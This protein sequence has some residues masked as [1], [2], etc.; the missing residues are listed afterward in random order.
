M[1]LSNIISFLVVNYFICKMG[2]KLFFNSSFWGKL[3]EI[4]KDKRFYVKFIR[5]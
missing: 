1:N 5:W 3:N 4:G 2:L